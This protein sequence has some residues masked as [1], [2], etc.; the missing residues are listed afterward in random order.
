MQVT[1]SNNNAKILTTRQLLGLLDKG[2]AL[3]QLNN[4]IQ[5]REEMYEGDH[6]EVQNAMKCVLGEFWFQYVAYARANGV[7]YSM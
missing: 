7:V 6:E 2:I 4:F 3:P 1:I 5:L